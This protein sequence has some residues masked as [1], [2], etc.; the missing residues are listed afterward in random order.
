MYYWAYG[1]LRN[2]MLINASED[3]TVQS[4]K[5]HNKSKSNNIFAFSPD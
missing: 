2:L 5:R 4:S 1:L 3:L